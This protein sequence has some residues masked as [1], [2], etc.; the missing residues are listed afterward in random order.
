MQGPFRLAPGV[1]ELSFALFQSTGVE[2]A[3]GH[4]AEVIEDG[5]VFDVLVDEIRRAK[6]SVHILVFIWRPSEPSDR[7]V[8]ALL[9]RARA[10]VQCRIVVDPVGS[11]EV[12]GHHDFDEK[13]E[14]PLVDGGC[15]VHYYRLLG[16]RRIRRMLGRDHQKLAIVDGRVG[17]TGGFGIWKVWLGHGNAPEN[18]RETS[19]RIEGPAIRQMQLAFSSAWQESGGSLLPR[20]VFPPLDHAGESRAGYVASVGRT[21]IANAY[22]SPPDAVLRQLEE[23]RRQSVDVRVLG[24]GPVHDVR[25]IRASQRS[26][27]ERLLRAGVRIWEYQPSMMHAKTMLVD[28]WLSVIG[29]TNLDPVAL[30]WTG[31]GSLVIEDRGV[32]AALERAWTR[33]LARSKEITLADG[34]RS[35]PW[36]RLARRITILLSHD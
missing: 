17:I 30:N 29:S 8:D 31:E 7:I 22:F 26:T 27:Y 35:G 25:V 1:E 15:E 11:E 36:R 4:R 21:G 3:P 16:N 33:D 10:G 2:L 12:S 19:V 28:D 20:D 34:G 24:P 32:A 6:Q 18:W 5:A 23:K 13:I 9:E 14:K